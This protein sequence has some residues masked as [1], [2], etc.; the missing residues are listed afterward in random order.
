MSTIKGPKRQRNKQVVARYSRN[1][2]GY[3]DKRSNKCPQVDV[4]KRITIIYDHLT[5]KK[6]I[7]MMIKDHDVNYS[8][9]RHILA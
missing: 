7:R 5:H 4:A 8:T 9:I 2:L 1:V 6:T 3:K